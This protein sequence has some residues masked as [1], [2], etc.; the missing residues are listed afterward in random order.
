MTIPKIAKFIFFLVV[1]LL[2]FY[3]IFQ[4]QKIDFFSLK[5]VFLSVNFLY[6]ASACLIIFLSSLFSAKKWQAMMQA[7]DYRLSFKDSFKIIMAALPVSAVT[8]TK[9]GDLIKAYYLKDRIPSSQTIGA[10]ATER[11][12]DLFVLAFYSF[13]GAAILKN[14]L[15]L[16]LSLLIIAF[17]PIFFL[18]INKIKFLS[19][20]LHISKIFICHPQK[21]LPV[22]FY[23]LILWLMPIFSAKFLFLAL[24][25]NISLFYIAAAFPVAIF[26]GLLP[27]TVAGM[28]S[29]DSAII[30][31]FS[32]WTTSSV[33]LGVGL[34]YSL[35]AY[36]F[37]ALLGLP[38]MKKML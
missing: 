29:R 14:E 23:A 12:I 8:P 35:F 5:E 1:T 32:T 18:L 3:L 37:L 33:C 16:G 22:L 17:I 21:L 26:V 15:I 20:F 28:G 6:L 25:A 4:K 30:Y 38:F 11:F 27:I 24:G 7:M 13:L 34:L 2:I 19:N 9:S 10:V 31:F 36:W